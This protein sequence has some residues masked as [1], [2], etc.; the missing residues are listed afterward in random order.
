MLERDPA[1]TEIR[2]SEAPTAPPPDDIERL[3][4]ASIPRASSVEQVELAAQSQGGSLP[5][6]PAISSRG[7]SVSPPEG[8]RAT[9]AQ[10]PSA[11]LGGAPRAAAERPSSP[12]EEMRDRFSMGDFSGALERAE[13]I[14]AL[15]PADAEARTMAARCSDVLFEMYSSRVGDF[16]RGVRVVMSPEKLRW[17]SLDHRAGFLLSLV[18]GVSSIDELLDVSGMKRL[19]A[20]RQIANL[21]EQKVIELL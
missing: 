15:N 6:Q 14:L 10:R 2:H 20:V 21:L 19:D 4:L 5:P 13:T 7:R 12:A 9:E 8:Q 1:Q 3:R 17:L 16:S 11:R 18:D